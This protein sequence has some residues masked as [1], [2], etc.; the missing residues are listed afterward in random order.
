[1]LRL[2]GEQGLNVTGVKKPAEAGVS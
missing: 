1:M 2:Q